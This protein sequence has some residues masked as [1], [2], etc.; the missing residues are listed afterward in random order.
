MIQLSRLAL[1]SCRSRTVGAVGA[2]IFPLRRSASPIMAERRRL[3]PEPVL[4]DMTDSSPL[5]KRRLTAR[6]TKR[7]S[8]GVSSSTG[9]AMD[10]LSKATSGPS[11][12]MGLIS[13]PLR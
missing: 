7:S 4:P 8:S 10:E 12:V 13:G 2:K 11:S 5:G 3:L 6:R 1:W 9:Q